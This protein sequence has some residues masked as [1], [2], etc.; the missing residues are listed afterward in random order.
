MMN[1]NMKTLS[2]LFSIGIIG[3]M[4]L[5]MVISN[6]TLNSQITAI[7]TM[8]NASCDDYILV[9]DSYLYSNYHQPSQN[10]T[11]QSWETAYRMANIQISNKYYRFLYTTKYVIIS[12]SIFNNILMNLNPLFDFY[13]SK[14][15]KFYNCTFIENDLCIETQDSNNIIIESCKFIRNAYPIR[16]INSY[17]LTA[18]FTLFEENYHAIE[19]YSNSRYNMFYANNFTQN[20]E[21]RYT[22]QEGTGNRWDN[23]T[24]GNYYNDYDAL[25]PAAEYNFNAVSLGFINIFAI[26]Q[27]LC[28]G[29]G[30]N[31]HLGDRYPWFGFK[32]DTLLTIS[33][34][35]NNSEHK[36][37]PQIVLQYNPKFVKNVQYTIGGSSPITYPNQ[38]PA[39]VWDGLSEGAH[40]LV[41][42][43]NDV[44]SNP[45]VKSITIIKNTLGPEFTAELSKQYYG[46]TSP[47]IVITPID[48]IERIE[49]DLAGIIIEKIGGSDQFVAMIPNMSWISITDGEINIEITAYDTLNNPFTQMVTCIKDTVKPTIENND[50]VI[51][52]DDEYLNFSEIKI[53]NIQTKHIT[54]YPS[55]QTLNLTTLN[56][57]GYYVVVVTAEDHAG[58]IAIYSIEISNPPP[59]D[60]TMKH[61]VFG[62]SVACLLCVIVIACKQVK[63][64]KLKKRITLI[65]GVE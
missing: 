5:G 21:I 4:I 46:I 43:A 59:E 18:N 17:N 22:Y 60:D 41:V 20:I 58:N 33:Q 6:A 37:I 55:I 39:G 23:G 34:P 40:A 36:T 28:Y 52:I 42:T 63:I 26:P 31:I 47:E 65:S 1:R 30:S 25:Y 50:N 3:S 51:S 11:G 15:I 2:F 48:T 57:V 19:L 45:I 24:L 53:I 10:Q 54:L 12:N 8:P 16:A 56:L 27:G 35:A 44:F 14:N 62:L 7:T 38:I 29:I 61:V 32:I 9:T 49:L 13:G 64:S